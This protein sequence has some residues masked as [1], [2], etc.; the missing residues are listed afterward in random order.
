MKY[1]VTGIV[2][3]ASAIGSA[4]PQGFAWTPTTVPLYYS[5]TNC[6][7]NYSARAGSGERLREIKLVIGG[8]D[9][10]SVIWGNTGQVKTGI[11][12]V[13]FDSS[14][15]ANATNPETHINVKWDKLINGTWVQQPDANDL[16]STSIVVKNKT[17]ICS[18]ADFPGPG[19]ISSFLTGNNY[20]TDQHFPNW[21]AQEH[22]DCMAGTNSIIISSHGYSGETNNG[23]IRGRYNVSGI[24]QYV[25]SAGYWQESLTWTGW[26]PGYDEERAAQM[27]PAPTNFPPLNDTRNPPTNLLWIYTCHTGEDS[28]FIN[29]L[30]PYWNAYNFPTDVGMFE[31]Q[32]YV[33]FMPGVK[34]ANYPTER[35]LLHLMDEKRTVF[36]TR[37][38]LISESSDYTIAPFID[39]GLPGNTIIWRELNLADMPI[40][41]DETTRLHGVWTGNNVSVTGWY[42]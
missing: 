20:F 4:A 30:F 25:R 34:I 35:A 11:I 1:I 10:K 42:R 41:G 15:F 39:P 26:V 17:L 3:L 29:C 8:E 31:N 27:A 6:R 22:F 38:D 33:G 28:S 36:R 37:A 16:G 21:T 14:H 5:G 40:Y 9:T 23:V 2:I 7:V 18:H 32:A 19:G 24:E 13:V 12:N